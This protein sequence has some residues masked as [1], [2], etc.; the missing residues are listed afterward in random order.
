MVFWSCFN[1]IRN[2]L[3]KWDKVN[4]F[5]YAEC[6]YCKFTS[7]DQKREWQGHLTDGQ[8]LCWTELREIC[9]VERAYFE[10]GFY[11]LQGK[12]SW[13][14][15]ILGVLVLTD[16]FLKAKKSRSVRRADQVERSSGFRGA[17][18]CQLGEAPKASPWA[19]QMSEE[20]RGFRS[21]LNLGNISP[22]KSNGEN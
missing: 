20:L 4:Q 21:S 6:A 8:E 22:N 5:L 17:L 10:V 7:G 13:I 1:H 9:I 2:T 15:E 18:G 12:V 14:Q 11:T 3:R 16:F 19:L